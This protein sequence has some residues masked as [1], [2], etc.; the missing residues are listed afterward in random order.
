MSD[1]VERLRND[2]KWIDYGGHQ[3]RNPRP[4]KKLRQEAADEI[5]RLYEERDEWKARAEKAE[6][7]LERIHK[8]D[9]IWA[10]NFEGI[11]IAELEAAY[12]KF[13]RTQR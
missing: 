8:L 10:E 12:E 4:L 7:E 11:S 6:A 9:E 3:T 13:I 2:G 1:I 5:D